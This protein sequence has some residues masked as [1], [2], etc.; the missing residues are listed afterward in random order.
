MYSSQ[1]ELANYVDR[2]LH[3][4]HNGFFV[5]C[6][7]FDGESASNSLFFE[8]DR[9]WTGLLVEA[10]RR[11]FKQILTKNRKVY[12]RA[13]APVC[14]LLTCLFIGDGYQNNFPI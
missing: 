6:G 1:T 14:S 10:N 4:R 5:E 8:T 7:A 2:V 3:G 13:H 12:A 11:L 9:N